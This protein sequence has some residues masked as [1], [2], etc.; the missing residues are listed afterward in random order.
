MSSI[1]HPM[2]YHTFY[3]QQE[4]LG[5][6][7]RVYILHGLPRQGM[8]V[9]L[10]TPPA[11]P[12]CTLNR[13]LDIELV[14][15]EHDDAVW[16]DSGAFLRTVK[17]MSSRD[18]QTGRRDETP[19]PIV[20]FA[21]YLRFDDSEDRSAAEEDKQLGCP[22]QDDMLVDE[23]MRDVDECVN[24]PVP[25]AH[26]DAMD[27]ELES[28]VNTPSADASEHEARI[29]GTAIGTA[30]VAGATP[31]S[32]KL[33]EQVSQPQPA[34]GPM[35]EESAAREEEV[36]GKG[37]MAKEQIVAENEIVAGEVISAQASRSRG[38]ESARM[39]PVASVIPMDS[40]P[41]RP[42]EPTVPCPIRNC[43]TTMR[44]GMK[45]GVAP[46]L[47][48]CHADWLE[49][50]EKAGETCL[51]CR[52]GI[53]RANLAGHFAA[54]HLRREDSFPYSCRYC[55][56]GYGSRHSKVHEKTC[57]LGPSA[58]EV[59]TST[60]I[61]GLADQ[62]GR[63]RKRNTDKEDEEDSPAGRANYK[64]ARRA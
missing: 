26:V 52:K 7:E 51:I 60:P 39:Q 22:V 37:T 49:E 29:T 55:G 9:T 56:K 21:S 61:E 11:G 18:A 14:P 23:P 16:V 47:D 6:A 28:E 33:H 59:N 46:H 8:N 36:A 12:P 2:A 15:L 50:Y 58:K 4:P 13:L 20:D 62:P 25:S 53:R 41:A 34:S 1:S 54:K 48:K 44:E 38:A 64:R 63:R 57:K 42:N 5:E 3:G 32:V 30:T 31:V 40:Y 27:I 19:E 17:D 24:R 45:K 10:P 43:G 35:G